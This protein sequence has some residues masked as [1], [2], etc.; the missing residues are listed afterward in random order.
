MERQVSASLFRTINNAT[1]LSSDSRWVV[2]DPPA[3][4]IDGGEEAY[5]PQ[6]C[7]AARAVGDTGALAEWL[8]S[9]GFTLN[10][11]RGIDDAF[12]LVERTYRGWSAF[13]L[14]ADGFGGPLDVFDRLRQLREGCPGLPVIL[15]SSSFKATD[16]STERLPLCDVCLA[17]PLKAED[18]SPVWLSALLNAQT[19]RNRK[20][21]LRRIR[22]NL[23]PLSEGGE[24]GLIEDADE[25]LALTEVPP[26]IPQHEDSLKV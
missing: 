22:F 13:I 24:R 15:A 12:E 2:M 14:F 18:F 6:I 21:E 11:T 17:T 8:L 10:V 19:W 3:A 5:A 7:I 9:L 23:A 26:Q 16:C 4:V 20:S 1:R 25:L